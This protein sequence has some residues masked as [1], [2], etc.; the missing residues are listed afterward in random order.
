MSP[1]AGLAIARDEA[2]VQIKRTS[3]RNTT[4]SSL[5]ASEPSTVL[6]RQPR[7]MADESPPTS[8][9][10]RVAGSPSVSV[11]VTLTGALRHISTSSRDERS[12]ISQKPPPRTAAS[13]SPS[14]PRDPSPP[15]RSRAHTW[16]LN[17]SEPCMCVCVCMRTRGSEPAAVG[18]R[19]ASREPFTHAIELS[20]ELEHAVR[21]LQAYQPHN[22]SRWSC[23]PII[24]GVGFGPMAPS[25]LPCSRCKAY[26]GGGAGC[27][28]SRR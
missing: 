8:A 9:G 10:A 7:T 15:R 13:A 17:A 12:T 21:F 19:G 3:S 14:R 24:R 16:L 5:F 27:T 18:G 2:Q 22:S 11:S 20:I 1:T 26:V 23:S 6:D 4:R 25:Q 28:E